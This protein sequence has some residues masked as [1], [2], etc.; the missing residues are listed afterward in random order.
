M[1]SIIGSSFIKVDRYYE[2]S[3]KDMV[4]EAFKQLIIKLK[5]LPPIDTIIVSSG[6]IDIISKS[7]LSALK[8]SE[9]L[10]FRNCNV[11]RIENG[12]NGA[13]SLLTAYSLVKSQISKAVMIIGVDKFADYPSK[14][15][16]DVIAYNLDNETEY[17]YGLTPHVYAA[18][19]AKRYLKT[20]RLDYDYLAE[21]PLLMHDYASE[22]PYAY[23][24]FKVDRKTIMES[25]VVTE[26]L[27]LFDFAARADGASIVLVTSDDIANKYSDAP[28]KIEKIVNSSHKVDIISPSL[29]AVKEAFNKLNMKLN[30]N[31][32]YDVHDSYSILAALEIEALKLAND[33]KPFENIRAFEINLSGG[34][35]AR[36]Y[37]GGAT[38]I[39][40]LAEA[41]MQLTNTFPGRKSS[42][43]NSLI[44]SADDLGNSV[45]ITV[46]RR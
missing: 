19:M 21:W 2:L 45:Y 37:P 7:L 15:I 43:E 31:T 33:S 41:Y 25:Q 23:L 35:K 9:G 27:R 13:A 24:K 46:L 20:R 10:G 36:G 12:D 30:G 4:I 1:V 34:L 26:P 3:E 32:L 29:P 18:L 5:E 38:A 6:Y 39:Y 14:Y 42:A 17:Q 28:V 40:Q 22:N 16:N 11:M 8:L 44:L